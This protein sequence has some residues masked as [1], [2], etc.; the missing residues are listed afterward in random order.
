MIWG[1]PVTKESSI[2]RECLV[3]APQHSSR[4][5]RTMLRHR[6]MQGFLNVFAR[7]SM[8]CLWSPAFHR[9]MD[10]FVIHFKTRVRL[11]IRCLKIHWFKI[12]CLYG[13]IPHF[14]TNPN[15]HKSTINLS[16][17]RLNPHMLYYVIGEIHDLTAS[18]MSI[19]PQFIVLCIFQWL[20]HLKSR[21]YSSFAMFYGWNW[22]GWQRAAAGSAPDFGVSWG[23][24]GVP[25]NRDLKNAWNSL[26]RKCH[27]PRTIAI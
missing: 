10:G 4:S 8:C 2:C 18:V 13:I 9:K 7:V 24:M 19:F 17:W 14:T 11:N 15:Q 5:Q 3:K 12:S 25:R 21:I 26:A 22:W 27:S 6:D 20:N 1:T 23:R 16:S